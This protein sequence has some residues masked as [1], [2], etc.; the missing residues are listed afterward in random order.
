MFEHSS[1]KVGRATAAVAAAPETR[2]GRT[3]ASSP[4]GERGKL[5]IWFSEQIYK[6]CLSKDMFYCYSG[7][8]PVCDKYE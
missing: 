8:L 3:E 5:I 2:A 1:S 6:D 4:V 7:L